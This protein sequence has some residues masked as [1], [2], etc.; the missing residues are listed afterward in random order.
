MGGK[1]A[2]RREA[3]AAG[4]PV[5]PGATEPVESPDD[6]RTLASEYGYPIADQGGRRRRRA[7]AAGRCIRPTRSMR[8]SRARAARPSRPLRTPSCM[9]RNTSRTPRHIEIQV[10]A[11]AHGQAVHLGERDCSIQ[12]RHQKLIEECPSPVLSPALRAEMG[13]ASVALTRLGRLCAALARWSSCFGM[14]SSAFWR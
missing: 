10:L 1:V 14:A 2:A 9:S 8:P 13:A 12:R 6:V 3:I 5:V 7:R 11:D 4:V